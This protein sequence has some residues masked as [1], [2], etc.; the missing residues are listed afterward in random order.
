M[1]T[2]P[3]KLTQP[4][5]AE[6][7]SVDEAAARLAALEQGESDDAETVDRTAGNAGDD[8]GRSARG[9]DGRF[10]ARNADDELAARG[11]TGDAGDG[12]DGR[13][14]TNSGEEGESE[15]EGETGEG[16]DPPE[17]WSAEHK[18]YWQQVPPELKPI[19]KKIDQDRV[20]F[21][22][23]K[24][25]EAADARKKA[26][27]D[28]RSAN[29]KVEEA[30]KWW[31]QAGPALVQAFQNKWGSVDWVELAKKVSAEEYNAYRAQAER[32]LGLL[33]E[34]ERRGQADMEAANQAA[35]QRIQDAKVESHKVMATKYPDYFG[36]PDKAKD[37]YEKLGLF[38][39]SKGIPVERI[40]T[41][42]EAPILEIALDAMRFRDAQKK[43]S[44]A[45]SSGA[46]K[47]PVNTAPKKVT[48]G[49]AQPRGN[50]EV[51][52]I[53]Q[54]RERFNS[55]GGNDMGAAQELIERLGL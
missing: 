23:Q 25:Q 17:F 33:Q 19:L 1:S 13:T 36:T 26:E 9:A 30:A 41:I 35:M 28:A 21:A 51:E 40:N 24:A 8:K 53:R 42:H 54:V 12:A 29:S 4:P 37:T 15:T 16:E 50:R 31:Q 6:S 55:S 3:E 7:L 39:H 2:E 14:D 49:P 18:E 5:P 44:A 22:N 48:P 46:A 38:L 47:T 20:A 11:D 52:R 43:A 27:E 32:E 34:A 10:T 45:T